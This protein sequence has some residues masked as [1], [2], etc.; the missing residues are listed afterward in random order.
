MYPF[1]YVDDN[2]LGEDGCK[3]ITNQKWP[4]T[5]LGLG[6]NFIGPKGCK[7]L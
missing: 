3:T 6:K 4:L 7:A 1:F 2:E 5:E